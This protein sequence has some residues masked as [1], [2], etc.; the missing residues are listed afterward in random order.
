LRI[1]LPLTCCKKQEKD[2]H[3]K[4]ESHEKVGWVAANYI[5]AYSHPFILGTVSW[6]VVFVLRLCSSGFSSRAICGFAYDVCWIGWWSFPV[7]SG[8]SVGEF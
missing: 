8:Y 2:Y 5:R 4:H 7:G 6:A 3:E 1:A